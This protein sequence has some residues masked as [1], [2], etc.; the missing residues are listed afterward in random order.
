MSYLTKDD[1]LQIHPFAQEFHKFI[2]KRGPLVLQTLYAPVQ[3]DT[4]AK[5]WEWVGRGGGKREGIGNFRDSI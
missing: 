4:R 3:G 2:G 1:I 5:K